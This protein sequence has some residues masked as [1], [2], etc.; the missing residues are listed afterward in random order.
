M[1]DSPHDSRGLL[2]DD[3]RVEALSA[4]REAAAARDWAAV[5]RLLAACGDDPEALDLAAEASWW[6]G[7]LEDCIGLRERCHAVLEAAGDAAGA[8]RVAMLLSDNYQFRGRPAVARGWLRRAGRLLGRDAPADLHGWFALREGELLHGT[9]EPDAAVDRFQEAIAAAGEAGDADLEADALQAL[10]RAL[11]SAGRPAEGLA[12]LDEAMLAAGRGRLNAYTTGKIYCSLMSAC[13]ELGDFGRVAEWSEVAGRWADREGVAVFPGLCRVHRAAVLR[14]R[15]AWGDAESEA[16]RA[17]DELRDVHTS[18]AAAAFGELGEIRRLLGDLDGAQ[19][20]FSCAEQL[21]G[22]ALPGVAL[23]RLAQGRVAAAAAAI[24]RGLR[25][26]A[27]NRLGRARLLP[28]AVQI[29]LAAGEVE[30]ARAAAAELAQIADDYG[31]SGLRAAALLARGQLELAAHDAVG[32]AATLQAALALYGALDMPYEVAGAQVL[33]A[34]ALRECGDDEG[35]DAAFAAARETFVRL[36]AGHDAARTAELQARPSRCAE[37]PDGLSRR[38]C[39]VLRL[40]AAGLTNRE[41]ATEL[42]LS[43]KTVARHVSNIFAKIGVGSRAAATAYA[44][45]RG[46]VEWSGGRRG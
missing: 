27:W 42:Y 41:I 16:R 29:G 34:Q 33:V 14:L 39:Q 32:A 5:R 11:I 38:E 8:A 44:F 22:D 7:H 3:R 13:E 10:G 1:G 2:W 35:A 15:G 17:C 25:S 31:S 43:E 21:G 40:V 6:L 26:T 46:I 18:N 4:A 20:A 19:H 30:A 12:H 28:A 36:G 9:G 45:E 37:P 23:L 24:D